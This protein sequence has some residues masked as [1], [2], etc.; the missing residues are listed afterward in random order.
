MYES[1]R[2]TFDYYRSRVVRETGEFK[3]TADRNIS[4]HMAP[5]LLDVKDKVY[6]RDLFDVD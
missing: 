3:R 4:N 6:T 1:A 2:H 5:L